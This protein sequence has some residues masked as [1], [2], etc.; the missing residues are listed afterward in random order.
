MPFLFQYKYLRF[1]DLIKKKPQEFNCSFYTV[2]V[3]FTSYLLLLITN[4][5]SNYLTDGKSALIAFKDY[6]AWL[7]LGSINFCDFS[8]SSAHSKFVQPSLNI[9]RTELFSPAPPN[10]RLV[11]CG[12]SPLLFQTYIFCEVALGI[13]K[14]VPFPFLLS[15][16][17][18]SR[19]AVQGTQPL[20]TRA[21]SLSFS[22]AKNYQ[23]FKRRLGEK[24]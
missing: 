12:C 23:I 4:E 24:M 5:D 6:W 19:Y 11:T 16:I 3:P 8:S 13:E 21:A 22:T 20:V 14:V 15:P 10:G 7:Y 1:Y 17:T 9:E 2:F 18:M